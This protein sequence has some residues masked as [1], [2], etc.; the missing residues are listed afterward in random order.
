MSDNFEIDSEDIEQSGDD[1]VDIFEQAQ[2]RLEFAKSRFSDIH[3]DYVT[4]VK[5]GLVGEQWDAETL[6]TRRTEQRTT[7]VYNKIAPLIRNIVNTSLKNSPAIKV[8]SK[9]TNDKTLCKFYDGLVKYIENES[10]AK[11]VYND[12][13]KNAVAGGIGVFE[14]VVDDEDG[15][16]EIKILRI[17]DPTSVYPD[18]EST[19]P[20]FSDAKWLFHLKNISKE[21]FEK[22]YP[23]FESSEIEPKNKD[24]F[25]D[26]V[27]I[28]EYWCVNEDKSVSWHI[29]NG[30]EVIDSSD[31][32]KDELGNPTPYPGKYIPYCFITGEEIWVEGQRIFKSAIKDVK[33]YQK[34][35]NYMQSEAIDFIGKT[36]KS[37]WLVSDA[38]VAPYKDF[39][40]NAN[41][42]NYPFLPYVDGK[43]V[44]QKNDPPAPPVGYIDSMTRLETDIR[45]NIG[46]RDPLQDIPAGQSGKA[47]N[48]QLSESNVNTF[49]W[50]DHLQR[51]IKRAGRII[52]DLIP[53]FYNFPH[54]QPI[55][56]IDGTYANMPVQ[57][58][59][60]NNGAYG[61]IDLGSDEMYVTIS[62]GASYESQKQQTSETLM[63]LAKI[64]P[65]I[66]QL[67]GDIIVRNLDFAESNEIADRLAAILPPQVQQI[68]DRNN[69]ELA[70][71]NQLMQMNAQLQQSQQM[72]QQLTQALNQKNAETEQLKRGEQTKIAMASQK[73]NVELQKSEL[74]NKNDL[75]KTRLDNESDERQAFIK[76]QA[77]IRIKELEYQIELL[78]QANQPQSITIASL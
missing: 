62:T 61:F 22:L 64:D 68:A 67:A 21:Q 65:R 77:D 76:S 51:A 32:K 25:C 69:S 16:P 66:I 44:P 5:F 35:Y 74:D 75:I 38:S 71:K 49:I 40:N 37:P 73:N 11:A 31:W 24:W 41:I 13:L 26:G 3:N 6:N 43:P 30:N 2:E 34:T 46:I 53:F 10:N 28:A 9:T 1:S 7:G 54:N 15:T 8:S 39:W 59:F 60:N 55:M 12:T 4:D 57:Q 42:K 27:T 47:I 48:L 58:A 70:M 52:V 17:T 18:P 29:L 72:I 20:D 63:E 23:G 78:K 33:D 36:A 19:Q 14:I 50:I 45:T 56:N